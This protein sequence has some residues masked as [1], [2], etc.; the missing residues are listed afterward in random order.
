MSLTRAE[1]D[2]LKAHDPDALYG[3][4]QQQA[5][6]L[7]GLAARLQEL[8]ARPGGHSQNSHRPPSSDGPRTPPRSQRAR[9]GKRPGGQPGHRGHTLT[10]S[11]TPDQAVAHHPPQCVRCGA[12]LA[13]VPSSSV[14]RRQVVDLPPLALVVTEH[15]AA[16]VCC[17]HCQATTVAAFPAHVAAPVQYGPRLLGL[18]VYLRH[19][20][21]LPYA[22]IRET[23]RDLFGAGPACDTLAAAGAA[24]A[25]ALAPVEAAIATA[26]CA[27]PHAHTD[28]TSMRVAGR[29]EWVHVVSTAALTHYARHPKRGQAATDAVGLLPRLTGRLIHDGWA[30]YWHYPGAHGLCN[31]HHL[32]ELTAVAEQPGQ[33]WATELHALLRAMLRHVQQGR[34]AGQAASPPDEC[35]AFVARYRDLLAAGYAANPPPTRTP[36]GPQRGR[37]KRTPARNLLDRLT[38]HEAAVLAFLHDWAVPFDNNQAERDLRMIKVQQKVS[39]TFRAA[40]GA[41]IFCRLR[42][43]ISTFRKHATPLLTALAQTVAGHP[44]LPAS[45]PG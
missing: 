20:Q 12:A 32:R 10:M 8:E 9:S 18:G 22:R 15:R 35:A 33:G 43:Y 34:A 4:F 14:A 19:Y 2:A 3:L 31:A 23:L 21:L 25:A 26:L 1:F 5:A 28:E 29:R 44:P 39:G 41:D 17:P 7:A 37:L 40:A 11:A 13:G 27:A 36:E 24:C 38:A 42:G 6:G 45:L 30:P 16:T